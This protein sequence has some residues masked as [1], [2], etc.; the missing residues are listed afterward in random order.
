MLCFKHQTV[1]HKS[2]LLL[3]IA[4]CVFWT[5]Q[6]TSSGT[7]QPPSFSHQLRPLLEMWKSLYSWL[8]VSPTSP[9]CGQDSEWHTSTSSLLT[10]GRWRKYKMWSPC[11]WWQRAVKGTGSLVTLHGEEGGAH[12]ERKHGPHQRGW[13]GSTFHHF[14][15]L[16]FSPCSCSHHFFTRSIAIHIHRSVACF[17]LGFTLHRRS[18]K[19]DLCSNQ[20][21]R[22]AG[23][24][25]PCNPAQK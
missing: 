1:L 14:F 20:E 6:E 23:Q 5:A 11:W 12:E 7:I 19:K 3:F 15:F 18:T 17:L 2:L 25:V 10:V 8:A 9:V 4:F 13:K 24:Y 16:Y 21:R 22:S